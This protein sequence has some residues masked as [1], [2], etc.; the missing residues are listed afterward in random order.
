MRKGEKLQATDEQRERIE[1]RRNALR[2]RTGE[3]SE[4]LIEAAK[5]LI[6]GSSNGDLPAKITEEKIKREELADRADYYQWTIHR[7]IR[8]PN[9]DRSYIEQLISDRIL[10][11]QGISYRSWQDFR[12]QKEIDKRAFQAYWVALGLSLE[13]LELSRYEP[14]KIDCLLYD[15]ILTLNH[16]KQLQKLYNIGW[17]ESK[18]GKFLINNQCEPSRTWLMWR[19]DTEI[20]S[21]LYGKKEIVRH[22]PFNLLSPDMEIDRITNKITQN[23]HHF[24]TGD[25]HLIMTI[26]HVQELDK[27]QFEHL[28]QALKHWEKAIQGSPNFFILYLIDRE[29]NK[30]NS[31]RKER[32]LYEDMILP[33]TSTLKQTDLSQSLMRIHS[34]L[35]KRPQKNLELLAKDF[36]NCKKKG[37]VPLFLEQIY[38]YFECDISGEIRWKNYP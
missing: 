26:D 4:A 6:F 11:P 25:Y 21:P 13:E 5:V 17:Q 15:E 24:A 18:L 36:I 16:A 32:T 35:G 30:D 1:A 38:T 2:W 8:K 34:S 28:L 3:Y 33:T 19:I 20:C 31:W 22:P 14:T 29:I 27:V 23:V 9:L 12:G 37:K 10:V 7:Q